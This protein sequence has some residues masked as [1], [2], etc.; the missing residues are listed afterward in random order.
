MPH[1]IIYFNQQWVG[2]HP[3]EW[4][5]ER[6][7]LARAVV[8]E[9]RAAGVLVVAGGLEEDITQALRRTTP[10]ANWSSPMSRCPWVNSSAA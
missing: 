2:D 9:M 1:Y 8:E 7:I 5:D 3:A 4:Y 6:G 10:A